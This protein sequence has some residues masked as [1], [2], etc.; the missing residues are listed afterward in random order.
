M[1]RRNAIER[2]AKT[3]REGI[4]GSSFRNGYV[5]LR[6]ERI[7]RAVLHVDVQQPNALAIVEQKAGV[8]PNAE[9][10]GAVDPRREQVVHFA[11]RDFSHDSRRRVTIDRIV[12]AVQI[13]VV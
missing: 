13:R 10:Y 7:A 2:A 12:N 8:V 3:D 5:A 11:R 4:T 1:D 9:A 6:K